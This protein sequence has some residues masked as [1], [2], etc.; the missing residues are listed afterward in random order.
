MGV[1]KEDWYP[2]Q[3]KDEISTEVE[4]SGEPVSKGVAGACR[5]VD[6]STEDKCETHLND[7]ATTLQKADKEANIRS[8]RFLG[9][10]G[11]RQSPQGVE[12]LQKLETKIESITTFQRKDMEFE[13]RTLS[14]EEEA[15]NE[16]LALKSAKDGVEGPDKT[17][18]NELIGNIGLG[19]ASLQYAVEEKADGSG[20]KGLSLE[21]VPRGQD[22][23]WELLNRNADPATDTEGGDCKMGVSAEQF[24]GCEAQIKSISQFNPLFRHN[25]PAHWAQD[26]LKVY[27]LGGIYYSIKGHWDKTDLDHTRDELYEAAKAVC[28][29][30]N[31]GLTDFD[32]D[33]FLKFQCFRLTYIVHVIDSLGIDADKTIHFRKNV[34]VEKKNQKK[35]EWIRAAVMKKNTPDHEFLQAYVDT[36]SATTKAVEDYKKRVA[37]YQGPTTSAAP[38]EGNKTALIVGVSIGAV[39][40]IGGV[41]G[42]AYYFWPRPSTG[43]KHKKQ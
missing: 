41:G 2:K 3:E 10:A 34:G 27:V 9:T 21:S 11:L 7:I 18:E 42:A 29:K 25:N 6:W 39:V 38:D 13:Y 16:F 31:Y 17:E 20:K 12:T 15:Q 23:A 14:G 22:A 33:K 4:I 35:V 19:G 30:M 40:L 37:A 26:H 1:N 8:V 5:T 36:T 43:K 28:N 32:D 24:K